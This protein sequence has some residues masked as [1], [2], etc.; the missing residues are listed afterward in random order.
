MEGATCPGL[1]NANQMPI[2]A[3]YVQKQTAAHCAK[4]PNIPTILPPNI[5]APQTG[6]FEAHHIRERGTFLRNV[7]NV[8]NGKKTGFAYGA[9][10]IIDRCAV[11][12]L[13][14]SIPA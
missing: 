9:Q 7:S 12:L 8:R 10:S 11:F 2:T 6:G 5:N 14:A 13:L 1:L 3:S 4:S